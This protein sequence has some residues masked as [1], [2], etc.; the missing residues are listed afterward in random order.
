MDVEHC[1]VLAG[2]ARRRAVFVNGG[3]PDGKWWRQSSDRLSQ[4]FSGLVV[5]GRDG[6]N[7]VARQGD[8]RRDRQALASGVA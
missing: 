5:L 8:S 6:F 4:L 2:E 3:R 1:K 7:Q